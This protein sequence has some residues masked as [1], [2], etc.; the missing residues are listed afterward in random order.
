V[1]R[2]PPLYTQGS[3]A[4]ALAERLALVHPAVSPSTGLRVEPLQAANALLERGIVP[5][6]G[7][8]LDDPITPEWMVDLARSLLEASSAGRLLQTP[9]TALR[10]TEAVAAERGVAMVAFEVP[11]PPQPQAIVAQPDALIV[12]TVFVPAFP[13]HHRSFFHQ[14]HFRKKSF[15]DRSVFERRI[16]KNHGPGQSHLH[17]LDL[18]NRPTAEGKIAGFPRVRSH[19]V[20]SGSTDLTTGGSTGL[21]AGGS[22]GAH[23]RRFDRGVP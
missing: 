7:W 18:R 21:T 9:E 3:V 4:V 5:P 19:S 22:T 23:R 8:M 6:A 17:P 13:L 15:K 14:P 16:P 1:E 2:A 20:Q 11:A 12:E 10:T